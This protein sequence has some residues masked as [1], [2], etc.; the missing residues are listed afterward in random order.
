MMRR[1]LLLVGMVGVLAATGLLVGRGAEATSPGENGRIAFSLDTGN[2]YQ[3][4]TIRPDG[5]GLRQ[6]TSVEGNTS[7]SNWSPDGTKIVFG[8]D[9]GA[10]SLSCRIELMQSDGAN[11]HDITPKVFATKNGCA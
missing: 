7:S 6:L 5:T 1:Q 2:G 11:L 10:I 8:L 3:V 4:H 9:P